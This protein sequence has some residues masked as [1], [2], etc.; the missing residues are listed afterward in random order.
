MTRVVVAVDSFK[1][2][3][4]AADA[5]AA[6]RDGWSVARRGES[7]QRTLQPA[8]TPSMAALGLSCALKSS[9]LAYTHFSSQ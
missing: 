8:P 6:V 9:Q 1:R 2:S 7:S 3:I 5:A 4:G